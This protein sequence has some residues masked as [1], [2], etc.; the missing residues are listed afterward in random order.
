MSSPAR[1]ANDRSSRL[2]EQVG[3]VVF[4]TAG[5]VWIG[6]ADDRGVP[7]NGV[8]I[9]PATDGGGPPRDSL[10]GDPTQRDFGERAAAVVR[11]PLEQSERIW[12]HPRSDRRATTSIALVVGLPSPTSKLPAMHTNGSAPRPYTRRWQ[13]ERMPLIPSYSSSASFRSSWPD[14]TSQIRA[15]ISSA[16]TS[17][18]PRRLAWTLRSRDVGSRI[19]APHRPRC[20][21]IT[22]GVNPATSLRSARSLRA[23]TAP[24]V[25][26]MPNRAAQSL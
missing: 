4:S 13:A 3:D 10:R 6:K 22:A 11:V 7:A 2:S 19:L 25:Q 14:G 24:P 5:P 18:E 21:P 20:S 16:C 23:H 8:S 12:G 26:V 17:S 15:L 9:C 1:P